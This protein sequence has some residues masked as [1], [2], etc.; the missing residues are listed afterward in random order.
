MI[1]NS[2]NLRKTAV[3]TA[4]FALVACMTFEATAQ[5]RPVVDTMS[6]AQRQRQYEAYLTNAYP[7]YDGQSVPVK[8]RK[9]KGLAAPGVDQ[10]LSVKTNM[11][12]WLAA[13]PNLE[14][15]FHVGRHFSIAASGLYS[16]WSYTS[17][18]RS[19]KYSMNTVAARPEFRYWF[20]DSR[21]K[22]SHVLGVYGTWSDFD[23]M[24]DGT[25]YQGTSLGGGISYAYYLPVKR[26]WAFEFGVGVGY[27]RNEYDKYQWDEQQGQN[28][29]QESVKDNYI[30]PT[31]LKVTAIYRIGNKK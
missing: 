4:L 17:D 25:G 24:F 11:L 22:K 14:L 15:E 6:K 5:Q 20:S 7:V 12:Y 13:A 1:R 28:V 2:T 9:V 3:V 27:L 29:F 16:Y 23:M 8:T 21:A 18:D 19:T 30:G 10:Y 31:Q 26:H